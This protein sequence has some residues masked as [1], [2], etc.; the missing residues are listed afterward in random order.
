[1]TQEE[2]AAKWHYKV[3]R[4]LNN[5]FKTLPNKEY[6]VTS[7][8]YDEQETIFAIKATDYNLENK[9]WITIKIAPEDFEK[10]MADFEILRDGYQEF[11]QP[12]IID[13]VYTTWTDLGDVW[14]I[15][16][17]SQKFPE[18]AGIDKIPKE[19]VKRTDLYNDKDEWSIVY[20][21]L[22]DIDKPSCYTFEL[23]P[24]IKYDSRVNG[25]IEQMRNDVLNNQVAFGMNRR[26]MEQK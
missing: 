8:L 18:K 2:F 19:K 22:F 6:V 21:S 9:H 16:F 15:Q 11:V 20:K 24:Q 13:E 12:I 26:L 5:H 1:M 4:P 3:I 7:A 14:Q 10:S 17:S 23:P 25:Y